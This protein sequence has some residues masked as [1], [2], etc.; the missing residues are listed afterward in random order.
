[1]QQ[2]V[3]GDVL[4][5][6]NASIDFLVLFMAGYFLHIKRRLFRLVL[7]SLVGGIYGVIILLPAL[8]W[9]GTLFIHF[10]MAF[11]LCLIAYAPVG[12][13]IFFSLFLS[14]FGAALLLGGVLTAFY[15]FLA[16]VFETN[17]TNAINS[18]KKAEFFLLYA[19]ISALL[20]FFGGRVF[21]KKRNKRE[22]MVEIWEGEKNIICCC[23]VDSGNLLTDPLSGKPVILVRRKEALSII[24]GEYLTSF[25]QGIEENRIPLHMRRKMR[26]ILAHSAIGKKILFG[27][28]PDNIFLYGREREKNKYE[29]DAILAI[30]EDGTKDF[31]GYSGIIPA[32][33][34]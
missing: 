21:S 31:A 12:R 32:S 24:S 9:W 20:V 25:E 33:L 16:N 11:I 6:V 17:S 5:L 4:F 19:A 15:G 22:M 23:L 28:I 2:V 3:Y 26:V 18:A 10:F 1:M 34:C 29:V 7:S 14:F 13:K 30:A 8:T 27:Y